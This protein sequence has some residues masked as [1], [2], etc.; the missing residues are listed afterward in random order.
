MVTAPR[1]RSE[2]PVVPPCLDPRAVPT[3]AV[4]YHKNQSASIAV[5][6]ALHGIEIL[7]D[8]K[9]LRRATGI[10]LVNLDERVDTALIV[11]LGEIPVEV[12]LPEHT[13]ITFVRK[14]KGISEKLVINVISRCAG[15]CVTCATATGSPS[16]TSRSAES[17]CGAPR[18]SCHPDGTVTHYIVV[19]DEGGVVALLLIGFVG[20]EKKNG[21]AI[22]IGKDYVAVV[23]EGEGSRMSGRPITTNGS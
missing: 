20:C 4:V 16:A 7:V 3:S 18:A 6:Q 11:G 8:E 12:I 19:L 10:L 22:V 23:K 1:R 13:R 21:D 14:Y 2:L 17:W 5:T 9:H 15:A